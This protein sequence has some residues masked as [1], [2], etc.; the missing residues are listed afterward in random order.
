MA[1]GSL[2]VAVVLAGREDR[3]WRAWAD[4]SVWRSKEEEKD[5]RVV[6]WPSLGWYIDH[7]DA[8]DF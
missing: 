1:G 6:I 5:G 4:K 8:C 2:T 7:R 3:K